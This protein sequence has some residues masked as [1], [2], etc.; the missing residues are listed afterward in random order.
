MFTNKARIAVI[1]VFLLMMVL[2]G[3]YH[4][5]ELIAI[6]SVFVVLLVIG[7]FKEGPIILAAKYYHAEDYQKAEQLLLQIHRPQWLSKKRR[8]FYEFMLGGICLKRNDFKA[9][10]QH[11]E[12]AAQYPLRNTN[13]HVAALVHVANICLRLENYQKADQYLQLASNQED[14]VTAKMKDVIARIGKELK[15]RAPKA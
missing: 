6:A 2:F 7:Y 8:G 5:Y 3:Y 1:F 15:N 4:N 10:E 12:L 9:A 13:D 11:Y 14:K